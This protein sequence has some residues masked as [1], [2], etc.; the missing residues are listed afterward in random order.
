MIGTHEIETEAFYAT[1][2]ENFGDFH[3][4]YLSFGLWENGITDYVLAAEH[5]IKRVADKINLNEDS[6]LLDVACGMG[7]QDAFWMDHYKCILIEAVDITKKHLEIAQTKN[8]RPDLHYSH[9]NACNLK[10]PDNFFTH[11]TG[12]EGPANFNTREKFFKEAA[13]VLKSGG[14]I[15]LSDY[16]V[17]KESLSWMER[18]FLEFSARV[19]HAPKENIYSASVYKAKL[20]EAGF[21]NVEIEVVSKNVI[22]AYVSEHRR[23]E[24]KKQLNNIRGQLWGRLGCA[25]DS[26]VKFLYDRNLLDYILV[27]ATKK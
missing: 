19:W 5:L 6:V 24:I 9:G 21:T 14:K 13:R 23:P 3:N 26:V 1:G 12:I 17:P 20:E 15:G 25:L 10:F 8:A 11:V 27:S 2:V 16:C 22:P 4:N 18:K 7:T